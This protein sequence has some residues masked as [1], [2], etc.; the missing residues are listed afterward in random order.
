MIIKEISKKLNKKSKKPK[1][2]KKMN[3][4]NTLKPNTTYQNNAKQTASKA[5][6][7]P[8]TQDISCGTLAR[9]IL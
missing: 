8:C 3:Q 7:F 5:H 6:T 2:P 4:N 1:L 9:C